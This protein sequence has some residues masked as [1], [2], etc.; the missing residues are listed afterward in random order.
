MGPQPRNW[1]QMCTLMASSMGD[2]FHP[3]LR[4]RQ[5]RSLEKFGAL[6]TGISVTDMHF[7]NP[8]SLV[9][10]RG[11]EGHNYGTNGLM[12]AHPDGETP[13]ST[14]PDRIGEIEVRLGFV[15]KSK[16]VEGDPV[17]CATDLG[18][19]KVNEKDKKLG[20]H[21]AGAV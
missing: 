18:P 1:L 13:S 5:E 10:P 19:T 8:S 7:Q 2:G 4:Q 3:I 12:T 9:R 6:E 11:F 20:V 16:W 21:C 15:T 17:R 14:D